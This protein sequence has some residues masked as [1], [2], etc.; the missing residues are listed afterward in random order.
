M[1]PLVVVLLC[2]ASL[3]LSMVCK[4]QEMFPVKWEITYQANS[5]SDVAGATATAKSKSRASKVKGKAFDRIVFIY[6]ENEN[7]GK[8]LSDREFLITSQA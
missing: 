1:L 6:F 3:A 2:L 4:L 5:T 8:A 7:Y